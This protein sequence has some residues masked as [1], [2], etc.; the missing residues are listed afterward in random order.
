MKKKI[1]IV[2]LLFVSIQSISQ[3]FSNPLILSKNGNKIIF[4]FT[5][6]VCKGNKS[7]YNDN[8]KRCTNCNY[9]TSR[10]KEYNV[11][12]V[13]K[14]TRYI[15][16]K[17]WR[18]TCKNCNGKG[19]EVGVVS[20]KFEQILK[21]NYNKMFQLGYQDIYINGASDGNL[22]IYHSNQVGSAYL[23]LSPDNTLVMKF[24]YSNESPPRFI[25][26]TIY[27]GT[28]EN[29]GNKDFIFRIRAQ[30]GY[31]DKEFVNLVFCTEGATKECGGLGAGYFHDF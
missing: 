25:Q 9:W 30:R 7:F 24:V 3:H 13:C 2:L 20:E 29:Y 27:S 5:C 21:F 18:V 15:I 28:W 11:C 26:N 17:K 14:N 4:K 22:I 19:Y 31:G 16:T 6:S 12:T 10:Q 8:S 23:V 1:F